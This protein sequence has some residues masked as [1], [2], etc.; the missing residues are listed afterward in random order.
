M[1]PDR[2]EVSSAPS[3]GLRR[4]GHLGRQ[5]REDPEK[6]RLLRAAVLSRGGR[7]V[8]PELHVSDGGQEVEAQAK[9]EAS[10]PSPRDRRQA[11][12]QLVQRPKREV[13]DLLDQVRP[14]SI[15]APSQSR[16]VR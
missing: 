14:T 5:P 3:E 11:W 10:N 13:G 16:F 9:V 8:D 4:R 15:S 2:P 1:E 6:L 12:R 7:A